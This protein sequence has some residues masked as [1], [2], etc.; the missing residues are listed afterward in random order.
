MTK[1]ACSSCLGN[2]WLGYYLSSPAVGVGDHISLYASYDRQADLLVVY[3]R[4]SNPGGVTDC[5]HLNPN[6]PHTHSRSPS[7]QGLLRPHCR[8]R[9]PSYTLKQKSGVS[10]IRSKVILLEVLITRDCRCSGCDQRDTADKHQWRQM[11]PLRVE[12]FAKPHCL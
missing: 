10:L 4:S 2:I 3:S 11:G 7:N 5:H 8:C 9:T 1:P 12:N 6:Q